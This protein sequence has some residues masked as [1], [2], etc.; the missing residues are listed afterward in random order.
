M[1]GLAPG[2]AC[3]SRRYSRDAQVPSRPWVAVCHAP[4]CARGTFASSPASKLRTGCCEQRASAAL[5]AGRS[6]GP[7]RG[8][9]TAVSRGIVTLAPREAQAYAAPAKCDSH[10]F[11]NRK[12]ALQAGGGAACSLG[13]A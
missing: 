7:D 11:L 10:E 2:W 8:L 3:V 6:I 9:G 12:T 4:R 5:A 1:N 13:S